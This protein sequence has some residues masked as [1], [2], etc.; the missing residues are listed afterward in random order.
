M[1]LVS[2][3]CTDTN[4]DVDG[5]LKQFSTFSSGGQPGACFSILRPSGDGGQARE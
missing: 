4:A 2:Y 3:K 5:T 1:L